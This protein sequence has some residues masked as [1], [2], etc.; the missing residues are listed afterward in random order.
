[1]KRAGHV[2][3]FARAP[4]IGAVKRRLAADIGDPAAWRFYRETTRDV[5]RRIAVDP[6][7]WTSLSVTPD[8]FA[9][10]G[11]FWPS[12]VQR[13]PQGYGDLGQRMTRALKRY[14]DRPAVIVGSDIPAVSADHIAAAFEALRTHD[15]VFGPAADGGYW[16]VGARTPGRLGRLFGNVRWSGPHAL[17]DTLAGLK[18]SRRVAFL[19]VLEDVDDGPGLERSR[20]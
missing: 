3:L 6:R 8:R 10:T 13:I 17:T 2:Y 14:P 1:M 12:G 20:V 5:L 7:W 16:L 4:M 9:E 11:R 19:D 15:L 18:P